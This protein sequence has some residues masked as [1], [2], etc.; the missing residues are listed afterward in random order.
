VTNFGALAI[1]ALERKR[2]SKVLT[3]DEADLRLMLAL[4]TF[5]DVGGY[6]SVGLEELAR[7]A[8]VPYGTARRSRDRLIADGSIACETS[9]GRGN[10]TK[11]RF[12]FPLKVLSQGEQFSG[13]EK[14]S[15]AP[16]SSPPAS[17]KLL[18]SAAKTAHQ[19]AQT[20]Q[21]ASPA[22]DPLALGSSLRGPA[23]DTIRAAVSDV[24]DEEIGVFIA[25]ISP[26][27][28]TGRIDR[29]V[30][31]F[32]RADIAAGITAIRT[33]RVR[34]KQKADKAAVAR[35]REWASQQ[36]DCAH[37]QPGGNLIRPDEIAECPSCRRE[38]SAR[39]A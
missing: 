30:A 24:T 8:R 4:E 15:P 6:R 3:P 18:T 31:G 2:R 7:Q 13:Q 32:A 38:R 22:L 21:D 27:C 19:N 26:K 29:Y 37:G 9:R 12:L 34:G 36:P 1:L 33:D 20:R 10:Y 35:W 39:P 14:C 28:R 17:E 16:D 23:A 25:E 5:P 11:W